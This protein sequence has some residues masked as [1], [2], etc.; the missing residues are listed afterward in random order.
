MNFFQNSVLNKHLKAQDLKAIKKAFEEFST[1]FHNPEIQQNIREAKEEQFQEGFLRELFVN[2][3]GY[4]L[5]PSPNFNLTTEYKN[6]KDSKKADGAILLYKQLALEHAPT[7]VAQVIAVIEL[8]G[9]ETTDLNR[10]E[11]QAFGYKNNQPEC[12]YVITSNFEKLR[13]YIDNAIEHIEFNLFTLTE[14]EFELLWLCLAF[15]NIEKN[16]PKRIKDESVS[17]EDVITKSLYNDY[18]LFKR[19]LHQNLVALN[20]DYDPLTLFKKSQKLLDRFLFLFF[21]ED[22]QLLPPNS[23]RLILD[24]WRD[25]QDR[26]VQIPLYDRFKKYFEYLNTG[27]KGK[28]YDVFA[29]NG[30]L[31][32]TDELLDALK[33][34]DELLYRHAMKL[35][36]YDFVSEVDVNILGHIFE[37]S[38]NELDEIKAQLEGQQVDKAKSKRKKDGVFYTPKYITKYIVDNTVGKLCTE[39]KAELELIEEEYTTDRKRTKKTIQPLFDKLTAY[40]TWLLQLTICDPACGSG[41]FLNQALDFLINEHKYIDEL[42]AKLFG[43][44]MVLSDFEKNILENNLFGVDLNE[45]S[46][47]IAKLSLWLRTAQLNRKLN[48]LNN[49]IKCG[50]SLIDDPAVAGD[51]AFNWQEEFPTVFPEKAKRAWHITTATHNSR[52]SQRMIDYH[53]QVGD[54]VWL[55]EKEEIIVTETI[56]KIV[57]EDKLNVMAYNICGD[58]MHIVMACEEEELPSIMQKIKSM[59]ARACNIAMGRTIPNENNTSAMEHA[60]SLNGKRGTTQFH[61]WTQKFGSKEIVTEEQLNNTIAY[62]QNNRVKHQLTS[63]HIDNNNSCGACSTA[64]DDT[65]ADNNGVC[66]NTH[67]GNSANSAIPSNGDGACSIAISTAINT[68][69]NTAIDTIAATFISSVSHALRTEYKGGFDVVIGNPPYGAELNNQDK[70][71]L[72]SNYSCFKGN[73]DIYS[74]FIQL[75]FRLNRTNGFWGFINPVSWQSGESYF[76]LRQYL[77]ENGKLEIGIKLPYDV[78]ADAYVDTGIYIIRNC[79]SDSYFSSVF[80]FPVKSKFY[81]DINTEIQM[82][83]LPSEY[84]LKLDS[85]KIVLN[86]AFYE[87][88]PKIFD[89]T[90][91]LATITNS[92]RGILPNDDDVHK[93]KKPDDKLFFV[94]GLYRYTYSKDFEG[95]NYGEHLKEKPKDY[96]YFQGERILIRRLINRQFRVMAAFA[97]NEFV[98]KKDLYNLKIDDHNFDLK[99]LLAIINSKLISFLK[100]KGSTNATKDDFGQLTLSDIRQIP[101]KP[102]TFIAQQPFNEMVNRLMEKIVEY[103]FVQHQLSDLIKEKFDIPKLTSKLQIWNDLEFGE[104]LNELKKAKVQLNLSSVAEW[105]HYFNEQKQ[106]ALAIK[107]EID[108]TDKEIDRMVYELYGLTEEEIGIVEKA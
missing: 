63:Q 91:P 23:V 80:E 61:L 22:R 92:I 11:A 42:Q 108:K 94:G 86:P 67:A 27:F 78:F 45:E 2:I 36:T 46:V 13:F 25:L 106:F 3:L 66:S 90:I 107:S 88:L 49:N 84:W 75:A 59:S 89:Q 50:N 35:S 102:I 10:I 77:V 54:P 64:V 41:A 4:T 70:D 52:Y 53:V 51:K 16:L 19:E 9:T 93:I 103:Q 73:F 21:A 44:A 58:H 20:P 55:S 43:D 85:L 7:P 40:R 65:Y 39:K 38:L 24:D 71:K 15:V 6:V 30:G 26:D 83:K 31:F 37:N 60:P 18:S 99:Y 69:I 5:N 1:Y 87:L 72:I 8:K 47:E 74:A 56:A 12:T 48:D 105:M 33:I 96:S 29:Y 14:K 32:K 28:R 81:G 100:I 17:Q 34:D 101:I 57:I 97:N 76:S 82:K 62:V 98:N 104:F 79:K 68:A 95:V